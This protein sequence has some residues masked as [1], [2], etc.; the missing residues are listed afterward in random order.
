M[1]YNLLSRALKLKTKNTRNPE[2]VNRV[3]T[4]REFQTYSD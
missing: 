2:A 3:K 4:E 1:D